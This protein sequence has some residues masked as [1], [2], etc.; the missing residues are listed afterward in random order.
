MPAL[1]SCLS[2]DAAVDA[3]KVL[4]TD[5]MESLLSAVKKHI[6]TLM[7]IQNSVRSTAGNAGEAADSTASVS[8]THDPPPL[9]KFKSLSANFRTSTT[10]HH[11]T[12]SAMEKWEIDRHIA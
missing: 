6:V 10:N 7:Q 9:K 4:L 5:D 12:S 1:R 2:V 11:W 3:A 8:E